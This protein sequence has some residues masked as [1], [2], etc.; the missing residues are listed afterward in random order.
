MLKKVRLK[1]STILLLGILFI[2]IGIFAGF[3]DYLASKKN[4]AYAEM[5]ILLYESEI[6]KNIEAEQSDIPSN[7]LEPELLNEDPQ[8]IEYNPG[9][10]YSYIGYLEVPKI[11]LKQGFVDINSKYNNV[12]YNITIINGSTFPNEVNNNFILAAH[13]GNCSYCY[14]N[15]LYKLSLGDIAYLTYNKVKYYYKIVNIYEVEKTGKVSIYRDYNKNV[16]TLI[17]CT[18]NSDAKQTVYILEEYNKE[19]I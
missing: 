15:K 8:P 18:R 2:A 14:F 1:N 6:P 11:N 4:K 5:N 13:S 10:A 17:T 9:Y 3:S 12:D 16:L 19:N 7:I